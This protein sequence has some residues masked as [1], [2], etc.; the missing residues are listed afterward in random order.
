[1]RPIAVD[2]D[3]V[4]IAVRNLDAGLEAFERLG[5]KLTRRSHHKGSRA[6]GAPIEPWG[7]AN[8]C[9]MLAQGY[10]E[11][12]GVT[13]PGKY[14]SA[15]TMVDRYE[16][17]HIVAFRPESVEA[18]HRVLETA[19]LPVDRARDLE[20]MAPYGPHG[21]DSRRAAFRNMYFSKWVF[22]EAQFQYTEHLTREVMWQ[23]HLLQHPNGATALRTVYFCCPDP[24]AFARK[25]APMLGVEPGAAGPN[26]YRLQLRQSSLLLLS[27]EAWFALASGPVPATLP[28]PVGVAVEVASLDAASAVLSLNRIPFARSNEFLIVGQ[29]HAGGT[30]LLFATPA[31]ADR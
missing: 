16:G 12:V 22:T 2:L 21:L 5:F 15:K 20:R 3:H 24:L 26:G 10:V 6:P 23:P 18:A 9:A 17:A 27:V 31:A 11:V 4:G 1:M 8:H 25:L 13:D 29:A 14:S 19:G 28:A 7:S 30:T